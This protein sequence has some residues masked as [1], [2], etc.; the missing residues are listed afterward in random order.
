MRGRESGRASVAASM[1]KRSENLASPTRS[2][3]RG[4]EGRA[5][6]PR[7]PPLH[8]RAGARTAGGA[9]M[10][11]AGQKIG[12]DIMQEPVVFDRRTTPDERVAR[13][14]FRVV[15]QSWLDRGWLWQ[16]SEATL[17]QR[18][19]ASGCFS[20]NL[21]YK[22]LSFSLEIFQDSYTL[23][24]F[25]TGL[26]RAKTG[27]DLGNLQRTASSIVVP[28][29]ARELLPAFLDA[30]KEVVRDAL[31]SYGSTVQYAVQEEQL[32]T[33][34]AVRSAKDLFT[35]EARRK[36]TLCLCVSVVN[37]CP[38]LNAR[39]RRWDRYFNCV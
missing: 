19:P 2:G 4:T 10:S 14:V 37:L 11:A 26:H 39:A 33:G 21:H 31:A 34:H 8:T 38:S 22:N 1:A 27:I 35:V 25:G 28:P 32:G 9:R 29:L 23:N 7:G 12:Q 16:A 18:L 5:D 13:A 24:I 30:S 20:S 36:A 6:E 3:C 17:R 15:V